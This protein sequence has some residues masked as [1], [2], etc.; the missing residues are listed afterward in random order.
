NRA[1]DHNTPI[2]GRLDRQSGWLPTGNSLD[3]HIKMEGR[4]LR[5]PGYRAWASTNMA[6]CDH[7]IEQVIV[8]DHRVRPGIEVGIVLEEPVVDDDIAVHMHD[9]GSTDLL[10]KL[11]YTSQRIFWCECHPLYKITGIAMIEVGEVYGAIGLCPTSH[12]EIAL[13]DQHEVA[14]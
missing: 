12:S 6:G 13:G 2:R 14:L 3:P 5:T 11:L 8:N 4:H 10:R 9:A 1:A 7:D